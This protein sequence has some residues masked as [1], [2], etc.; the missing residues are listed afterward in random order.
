M[1]ILVI[2]NKP[3]CFANFKI[4]VRMNYINSLTITACQVRQKVNIALE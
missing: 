3:I 2:R 4:I 1:C